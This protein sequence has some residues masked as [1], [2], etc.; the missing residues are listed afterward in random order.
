MPK[1][2]VGEGAHRGFAFIDYFNEANAKVKIVILKSNYI[3]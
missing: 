3:F 1:K 2:A